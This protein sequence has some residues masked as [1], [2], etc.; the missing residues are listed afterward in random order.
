MYHSAVSVLLI[1]V[2][3][4][5]AYRL[6]WIFANCVARVGFFSQVGPSGPPRGKPRVYRWTLPIIDV[7]WFFRQK[8]SHALAYIAN[9]P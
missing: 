4:T 3:S 9:Y 1:F 2:G 8:F 7:A 6:L 5:A